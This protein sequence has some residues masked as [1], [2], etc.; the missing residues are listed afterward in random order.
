MLRFICFADHHVT[1][2]LLISSTTV[3]TVVSCH[4][5]FDCRFAHR[6]TAQVLSDNNAGASFTI[7]I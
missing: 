4:C 3:S 6:C 2:R 5:V 7:E 1:Y